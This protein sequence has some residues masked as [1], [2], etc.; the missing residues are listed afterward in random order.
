MVDYV[1]YWIAVAFEE[2]GGIFDTYL[3]PTT[4]FSIF[5]FVNLKLGLGFLSKSPA[6]ESVN[7]TR[8]KFTNELSQQYLS[9]R[10]AVEKYAFLTANML[11]NLFFKNPDGFR[12]KIVRKLGRRIVLD[13]KAL[14]TFSA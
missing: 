9:K 12:D 8:R 5:H 4:V 7:I 11:K 13:E 3:L 1:Y 10:Q 2:N 6:R 14:L